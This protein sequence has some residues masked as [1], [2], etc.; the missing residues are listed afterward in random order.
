M[1]LVNTQVAGFHTVLIGVALMDKDSIDGIAFASMCICAI[2]AI[3]GT[4]GR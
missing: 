1:R 2:F 4:K 3:M